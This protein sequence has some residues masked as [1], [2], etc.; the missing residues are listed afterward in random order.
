MIVS[1]QS[2][3]QLALERPD[4][5]WELIDGELRKKPAM[6]FAHT[7]TIWTVFRGL[8]SQIDADL[9]TVDMGQ[10]RLRVPSGSYVI[11]DVCVLPTDAVRRVIARRP[12]ELAVFD[13]PVPLVVEVW[14]P[15]TGEYDV[16][17]KLRYY[18]QRRDAEI[19]LAHPY[20]RWVRVWR[21]QPAGSY[22][23]TLYR[24]GEITPAALPGVAVEVAALFALE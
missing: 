11:P 13:D 21:Q 5:R 8:W 18:Q 17:A 16:T 2:Y 19:W 7:A 23:E 3:E 14:S 12:R 20:E 15:S 24:A 22:S 10:L 1:A 6:T 9:Y 4:E